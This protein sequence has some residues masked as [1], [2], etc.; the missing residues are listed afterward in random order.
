[1]RVG[2]CSQHAH[3]NTWNNRKRSSQNF[4]INNLSVYNTLSSQERPARLFYFPVALRAD[5]AHTWINQCWYSIRYMW[6][7][8]SAHQGDRYWERQAH[9]NQAPRSLGCGKS[10]HILRQQ[11]TPAKIIFI[12]YGLTRV[13][14][15][16]STSS[17]DIA[18]CRGRRLPHIIYEP[19]SQSVAY[20]A[21]VWEHIII[22]KWFISNG[23]LLIFLY[24]PYATRHPI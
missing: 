17:A 7:F 8:C 12:W 18:F 3:Q 24:N 13:L 20:P 10:Y 21:G 11:Q 16:A 19:I 9:Q 14:L 4:G 15:Y 1:M 6:S 23:S 22:I 5:Q 2:F